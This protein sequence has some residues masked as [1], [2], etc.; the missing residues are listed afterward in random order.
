MSLN[1]NV[2]HESPKV[3]LNVCRN[4][5]LLHL[6]PLIQYFK[7]AIFKNPV[8]RRVRRGLYRRTKDIKDIYFT[9]SS[10]QSSTSMMNIFDIKTSAY[11]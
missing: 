3:K 5:T 7:T 11:C 2:P 4:C 9:A 6:N 10:C 1:L 8:E